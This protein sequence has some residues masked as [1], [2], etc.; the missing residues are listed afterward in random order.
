MLAK[1]D[2]RGMSELSWQ[3]AYARRLGNPLAVGWFPWGH[4]CA[5]VHTGLNSAFA[6]ICIP[7]SSIWALNILVSASNHGRWSIDLEVSN[8]RADALVGW[9]QRS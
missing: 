6:F 4:A 1:E 2:K 5:D 8:N 9:D 7:R 3:D